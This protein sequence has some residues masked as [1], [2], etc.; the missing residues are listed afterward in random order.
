MEACP[1]EETATAEPDEA[2]PPATT[3]VERLDRSRLIALG[4]GAVGVF[5]VIYYAATAARPDQLA[6]IN[7][8]F[9][10]AGLM[11]H[12][13]PR[14]YLRAV[15]AG[16]R[17]AAGIILQFPFYAG[18]M[19]M[20]A[21]SGLARAFSDWCV[22]NPLVNEVTFAPLAFLSAAVVN[23]FVPSGGGQVAVQGRILLDVAGGLGVPQGKAVM[24]LAYGDQL[25]NMLQPFWALALL[26][27]T[28]LKARQIIGYTMVVMVLATPVFLLAL[29]V[30]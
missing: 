22:T 5:A 13:T 30:F 25:T 6:V 18:I 14:A 24:A 20:M 12:G 10:F 29:L 28:G 9:L 1:L 15:T 3:P 7:G 16:T 17:G 26:G 8:L 11:L 23:V 2:A 27:I 21:A 19:G 4:T